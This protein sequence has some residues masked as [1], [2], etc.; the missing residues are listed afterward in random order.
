MFMASE[1]L[2]VASDADNIIF[3]VALEYIF[4]DM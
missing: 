1:L 4:I 2:D 3:W